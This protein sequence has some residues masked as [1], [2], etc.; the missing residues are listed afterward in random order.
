M[1]DITFRNLAGGVKELR[2]ALRILLVT[3]AAWILAASA[4]R[5]V[6]VLAPQAFAPRFGDWMLYNQQELSPEAKQAVVDRLAPLGSAPVL[7]QFAQEDFYVPREEGEASF[8]ATWSPKKLLWY[9]GGH[10]LNPQ[11]SGERIAWLKKML[12]LQELCTTPSLS[13]RTR[14]RF[15][16][17]RFSVP[18]R[19]PN[20][21]AAK[22]LCGAGLQSCGGRPRPPF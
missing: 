22:V 21:V 19:A 8:A 20:W 9:G 10:G 4:G 2:P 6:S 14:Q 5:C 16:G 15:R 13:L 3:Q 11:A 7:L 1:R 17:A 18:K 12:A